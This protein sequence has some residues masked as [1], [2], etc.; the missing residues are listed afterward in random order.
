MRMLLLSSIAAL[1]LLVGC[2]GASVGVGGTSGNV[3]VGASTS[4]AVGG[5]DRTAGSQLTVSMYKINVNGV[6]AEI[7]TVMFQITRRG[8]R[9]EPALGGLPPGEH[10]FHVHEKPD[11]GPGEKDGMMVA[12]LAAGGHFDPDAAGKHMGPEGAGH[13]GDLPILKV[14]ADGNATEVMFAEHLTV[15][16]LRGRSIMIHEGGDNYSDLPKPLGGGGA[17]IACGVVS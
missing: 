8:L 7:G 10:G 3:G 2:Q 11:C 5:G 6:G 16:D 1:P 14:D 9:I 17:R 15:E 12:G 4:V 13:R